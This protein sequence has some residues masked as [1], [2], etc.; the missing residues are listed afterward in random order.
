MQWPSRGARP[1]RLR[2]PDARQLNI[3]IPAAIVILDLPQPQLPSHACTRPAQIQKGSSSTGGNF[4]KQ[5]RRLNLKLKLNFMKFA[6]KVLCRQCGSSKLLDMGL[7]PSATRFAGQALTPPWQGG[8]LY[9]CQECFLAFRNPIRDLIEYERLYKG[10]SDQVW[11]S[12]DLRPD[13]RQIRNLIMKHCGAG[14]VLD[15]G[16]YIGT[17]LNSLGDGYQKFGVEPSD[18]ARRTAELK[19]IAIIADDVSEL[20]NAEKWHFDVICAVDVVEHLPDP[21]HFLSLLTQLLRP[22]GLLLLSTG[23]TD[24]EPWQRVGGRYWYCGIPEHISFICRN[25]AELVAEEHGLRLATT[26]MYACMDLDHAERE[27]EIRDFRS[28]SWRSNL[29]VKLAGSMPGPLGKMAPRYSLGRPGVFAD[30]MA[31]SFTKPQHPA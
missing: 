20:L 25:W 13:Q 12:Q 16:C 17:L 10:A 8:I 30:H 14:M 29:K 22:G 7:I 24:A 3:G 26:E 31:F 27:S 21:R 2:C 23:T 11:V 15:V 6:T 18:A 9:K 19:G 5:P 28:T 4:R 1:N